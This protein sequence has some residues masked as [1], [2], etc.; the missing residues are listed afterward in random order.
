M[1]DY[2][3]SWGDTRGYSTDWLSWR[4]IHCPLAGCLLTDVTI[5]SL[6]KPE[7][8]DSAAVH[9]LI[10]HCSV[11]VAPYTLQI[12]GLECSRH[13]TSSVGLTSGNNHQPHVITTCLH[14]NHTHTVQRDPLSHNIKQTCTSHNAHTGASG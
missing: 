13:N 7:H 4:P 3:T 11:H 14:T 12:A 9:A 2:N 6:D 5:E 8:L 10:N 1:R